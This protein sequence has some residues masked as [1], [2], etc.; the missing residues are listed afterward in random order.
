MYY[1]V[2]IALER[3]GRRTDQFCC[4]SP[5]FFERPANAYKLITMDL[6]DVQNYT[7]GWIVEK[8]RVFH[9]IISWLICLQHASSTWSS[10]HCKQKSMVEEIRFSYTK[11]VK[12]NLPQK[13]GGF[14]YVMISIYCIHDAECRFTYVHTFIPSH[15]SASLSPRSWPPSALRGQSDRPCSFLPY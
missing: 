4:N 2:V 7:V 6:C 8:R 12:I 9:F 13:Q 15:L 5:H 11:S 14:F 3:S 1:V 10:E